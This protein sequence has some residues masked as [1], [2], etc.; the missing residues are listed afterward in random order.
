MYKVKINNGQEYSVA[1]NRD[2]EGTIDGEPFSAEVSKLHKD[3]YRF[4]KDGKKYTIEVVKRSLEDKTFTL[5]IN[6]KKAQVALTDKVDEMLKSLGFDLSKKKA[7]KEVKAP[8]P[9]LVLSISCAD[10][11]EVKTGDSLLILEAMKMENVI[12]SPG[13]GKVK[14]IAVNQGTA[15]DKNQVLIQFE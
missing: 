4:E 9:G 7:V 3:V 15:V 6:G 2:A 13:D 14:R 8:M 5:K 10:G 12:K 1:I 11:D